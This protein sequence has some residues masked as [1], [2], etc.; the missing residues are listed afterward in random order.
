MFSWQ[1]TNVFEYL[2][3]PDEVKMERDRLLWCRID[4][5]RGRAHSE[6]SVMNA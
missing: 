6:K 5:E 3:F 1:L 4:G 2:A